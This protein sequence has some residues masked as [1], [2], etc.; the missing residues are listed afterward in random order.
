MLRLRRKQTRLNIWR[1]L[2]SSVVLA[3]GKTVRQS[4]GW[5]GRLGAV[6]LPC[7]HPAWRDL[8]KDMSKK[9]SKPLSMSEM[10]Q[11]LKLFNEKIETVRKGRFVPQ[12][13]RPDHG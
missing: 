4:D 6:G 3:R 5:I 13:F 7:G 10:L 2:R 11:K 9:P 1:T 12:V 8:I